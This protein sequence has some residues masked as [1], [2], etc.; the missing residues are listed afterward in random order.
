V[1]EASE[2]DTGKRQGVRLVL[3]YDG[4]DFAGFQVQPGQRTVQSVVERAVESM[5][6]HS[7]RIRGAGRTDAGVHALGQ[8]AAFDS[9][10]HIAPRGWRLGLNRALPDDVRVQ[11]VAEVEPGYNPRFDA[12]SKHYRYLV[13]VGV[14]ENPLL[15]K[16]AWYLGAHRNLDAERMAR[17]GATLEGTHDFQAFRASNDEC[18]TSVRTLTKVRL[19]TRYGGDSDLWAIDV[20]GTA[21]L[22]NMVRI[23]A[24]TLVDVSRGHLD[25]SAVPALLSA[26]ASRGDAGETA[27]AHG[28]TMVSVTL[29]RLAQEGK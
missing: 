11:D 4:T 12:L 22:K 16:R 25:E 15:R 26:E 6:G 3:A 28:L 18:D 10:R 7:V 2:N 9:E 24:G 8:L 23:I 27:P 17:A 5:A 19:D 1:T 21:F 20:V 29:G 14:S 13:H